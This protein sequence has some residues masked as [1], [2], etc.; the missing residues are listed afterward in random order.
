MMF[1]PQQQ[2]SRYGSVYTTFE[3]C[4]SALTSSDTHDSHL[5]LKLLNILAFLGRE[6]VDVN[7]FVEAF[8][9][10]H[11]LEHNWRFVWNE[12]EVQWPQPYAVSSTGDGPDH[13][14]P[15]YF[16]GLASIA[17]VWCSWV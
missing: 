9:G 5:A 11:K 8:D 13:D 4:A 17:D 1:R 10:C 15:K 16:N 3:V 6:A 2:A 7:I 12:S 14:G